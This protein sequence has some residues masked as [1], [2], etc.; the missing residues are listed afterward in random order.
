[1]SISLDHYPA[2]KL[3]PS[4][5]DDNPELDNSSLLEEPDIKIYQSLIGSLQWAITLGCFDILVAV[6]GM[7]RF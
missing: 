7:S 2:K 5:K 1:M 6:I 3:I 4:D